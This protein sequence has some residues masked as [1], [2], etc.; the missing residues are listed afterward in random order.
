VDV[1]QNRLFEMLRE[2]GF[3][4]KGG[5]GRNMP[6]Q[7]SMDLGLFEIKETAINRSD[8][9][10]DVKKTPKVTGRGQVYFLN[11]FLWKP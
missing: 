11:R 9:G 8:G 1:G 7:R 10:I 4:V 2:E 3:L 6:T 5:S